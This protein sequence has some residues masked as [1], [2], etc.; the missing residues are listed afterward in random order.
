MDYDGI[1]AGAPAIYAS[2]LQG[3][4]VWASQTVHKDE[5]SYIPPSKYPLIH[6]AVLAQCDAL[7]GVKDG[8]LEDPTKC[9][10]DLNVLACKDSDS[11]KCL[12]APQLEAA[13]KLYSGPENSIT[14][15]QLFPGLQPGSELGWSMLAGP[16]PMSLATD[17]YKYLVLNNPNWDYKTL[18]PDS[19]F[20][21][22]EKAI[23]ESMDATDP[24]LKPFVQRGG[25]LL[26]YHGWS[27]P[28]I[29]PMNTVNYYKSVEAALGDR[30]KTTNS[31]R[32]FMI[33]GMNHCQGGNGTD[34]FDGIAALARWVE[35]GKAPDRIEAS[36]QTAGKVDRTRP[37]CPYP[38][39]AVYKGIG[40]TDEASNF[41][42]K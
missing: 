5:T 8:V 40:S 26:M 14:G 15:R 9:K 33:P 3:M 6:N 36:H 13:A 7:D 19:D 32:L 31:V 4:Q 22:A 12:T 42:C 10:F 27:D 11:A 18:D 39:V 16:Q 1:L 17:V 41:V 23:R 20:G 29:P 35:N 28:G 38:Q 30:S 25:K 21:A 37:L 24:N 34:K 2:R